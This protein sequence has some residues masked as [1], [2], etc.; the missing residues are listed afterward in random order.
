MTFTERTDW[1][2]LPSTAT[3]VMAADLLRLE[4]GIADA[5]AMLGALA[6][7]RDFAGADDSARFRDACVNANGKT[8]VIPPGTTLDSGANNP[9]ILPSGFHM[10]CG[11]GPEDEFGYT[12]TVNLRHTGATT[13]LGVFQY[14]AASKG[15]KFTN[16]SFKGTS[17]T[18]AFVDV[19][20]DGSD[21]RFP[22]YVCF[23]SV[24]WN[25]FESIMQCTG[26]GIQIHGQTYVDNMA[27]TRPPWYVAG[28]DHTLFTAGGLMEMGVVGTYATRAAL[29]AMFRCGV[30][31]NTSIGPIYWTGSPTTPVRLD[32]G[33]SG[34]DFSQSILEGR[35]VPGT[36][37]WCA[38]PLARLAGGGCSFQNREHGYAMRSPADTGWTPGGFYQVEGS[39]DVVI[40]GGTFQPYPASDYPSY[41]LPNASTKTAGTQPHF[42]WVTST[43]ARLCVKNIQRGPNCT[44]IPVVMV[45]AAYSAAN[46]ITDATVSVVTY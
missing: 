2:N 8:V 42:A 11:F 46:I 14:A 34:V 3:P 16:I 13:T 37:L 10:M 15:Q 27:C 22:Q 24:S 35:P 12:A 9:Y 4:E 26:T 31:S 30:L 18:R 1:V 17:T 6:P 38:G 43:T 19:A 23:Q 7:L 36:T 39:A 28:S 33:V 40:S 29:A 20:L 32:G 45:P 5:H 25:Q 21:G 41:T 44:S